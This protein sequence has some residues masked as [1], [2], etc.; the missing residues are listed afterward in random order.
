MIQP[1]EKVRFTIYIWVQTTFVEV[2]NSTENISTRIFKCLKIEKLSVVV[3]VE[4]STVLTRYD[5]YC[6]IYAFV[7]FT[8]MLQVSR[9]RYDYLSVQIN[10][11][12]PVT[13]VGR[14]SR[15]SKLCHY[16]GV[17][18]WWKTPELS[19]TSLRTFDQDGCKIFT[20]FFFFARSGKTW[21]ERKRV[22]VIWNA[23]RS[24]DPW[25][26]SHTNPDSLQMCV[27]DADTSYQL[28]S[29]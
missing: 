20:L 15:Q 9:E 10:F 8:H 17:F 1:V 12:T 29:F 6:M 25:R 21:S 28:I 14:G 23:I 24:W 27:P 3:K 4:R 5:W 13:A 22:Q 18:H 11:R 2:I 26:T 7:Q 16:L 19:S